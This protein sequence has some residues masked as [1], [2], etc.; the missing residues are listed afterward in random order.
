MLPIFSNSGDIVFPLI[1]ILLDYPHKKKK[2]KKGKCNFKKRKAGFAVVHSTDFSTRMR[3]PSRIIVSVCVY[4]N[5]N[6]IFIRAWAQRLDRPELQFWY[7]PLC[8][9]EKMINFPILQYSHPYSAYD[10][11]LLLFSHSVV[12]NSL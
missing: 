3:S 10:K 1:L 12:S 2:S 8:N 11:D 6:E 7:L 4:K 9:P 5:E